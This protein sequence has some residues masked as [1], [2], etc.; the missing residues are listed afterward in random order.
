MVVE[1]FLSENIESGV[2]VNLRW[3]KQSLGSLIHWPTAEETDP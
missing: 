3:R 1:E 2:P